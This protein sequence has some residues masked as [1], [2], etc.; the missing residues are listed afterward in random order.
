MFTL[1][2]YNAICVYMHFSH[3]SR[4]AR[5]RLSSKSL[6]S[7]SNHSAKVIQL[8]I[9]HLFTNFNFIIS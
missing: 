8:Y 9:Y 6:Y 5:G 7:N 4:I 2:V 1:I 3:M